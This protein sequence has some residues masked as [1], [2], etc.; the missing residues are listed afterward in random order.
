MI[1][2]FANFLL[3]SI[4]DFLR[5]KNKVDGDDI[6]IKAALSWLA[7]AQ[8]TNRDGGVSAYYSLGRGWAPS[9]I[10]TTGY[11]IPTF[12]DAYRLYGESDYKRRAV[13]MADFILRMQLS[14]GSFRS[15]VPP[16]KDGEIPNIF[17][18]AQDVIG[19][20]SAYN[21]TSETKYLSSARAACDF[22]ISRQR[23]DG[24]FLE[25]NFGRRP[26]SYH[27]RVALSL[28]L[29]WKLCGEK[30]FLDSAL[31]NLEWVLSQQ[32]NRGWFRNNNLFGFGDETAFTHTISYAMEGL[33]YSGLELEENK[34]IE[35]A[36]LTAD[37]LLS[38]YRKYGFLPATFDKNFKSSDN[39]T[40]LTGDAQ[41][42][43]VWLRLFLLTRDNKY[44]AAA[45]EINNFL[46]S[47]QFV[48]MVPKGILGGV[49]GSYPIYGDI[50]RNKG[51]CRMAY[52][53]WATKFFVDSL[54]L[55]KE[56]QIN[57]KLYET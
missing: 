38:A 4:R 12:L 8:D 14:D 6:H 30:K 39:Y 7:L 18:T 19:L 49:A 20:I 23:P 33:F 16:S 52:L 32:N 5:I 37:S 53:N 40:C 41:I 29:C 15:K 10:E 57:K 17:D 43:V 47:V 3:P 31:G 46:K 42:S 2:R 9:F 51:Y 36:V 44:L 54:I 21:F 28:V 34:Y 55:E 45:K 35:R 48:E 1:A 56:V 25:N 11:I 24:S 26:Y 50:L 13:R 27:S 22:L